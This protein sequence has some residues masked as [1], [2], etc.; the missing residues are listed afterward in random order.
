M[1]KNKKPLHKQDLNFVFEKKNY[2][3]MGIGLAVIALG[4]ILMAGG[5]SDDP[6]VFNEEI[7]NIRRIRVA[8]ALVLLGFAIEVY[9]ILLNPRK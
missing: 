9:A 5:G 2:I 1:N 3:V 4:F 8:P 7:Y 6:N